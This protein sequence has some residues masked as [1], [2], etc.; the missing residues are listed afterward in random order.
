[1][2]S[3]L[4]FGPWITDVERRIVADALTEKAFY[5][6]RSK[7][8]EK[9]EKAFAEYHNRKHALMTPNCTQALH[10]LLLSLGIK[11][12]DEVIVADCNWTATAAPIIYC[13]AI[14]VFCDIDEKNWCSDPDS[15]EKN[16]SD[17]TKAIIVVDLY[18]NIPDMDRLNEISKK[19]YF[20]R[21]KNK[22]TS[23]SNLGI[24]EFSVH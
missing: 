10:L 9:F 23:Y 6:E 21:A 18:G 19:Y 7:Y 15:V 8:I 20:H 11:E 2:G 17:K 16:I 14:P 3:K 13:K 22:L 1:M 4:M 24:S 5:E 12:G